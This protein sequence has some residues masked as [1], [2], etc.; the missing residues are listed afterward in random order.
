MDFAPHNTDLAV[1]EFTM[2]DSQKQCGVDSD[3]RYAWPLKE[4]MQYP[5]FQ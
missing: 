5:I 4:C 1:I 3:G 2:N